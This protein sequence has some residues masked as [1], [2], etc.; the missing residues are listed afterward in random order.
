MPEH[1]HQVPYQEELYEATYQ[2]L[3]NEG[4]PVSAAQRAAKVVASDKVPLSRT[5]EQQKDIQDALTW[6]FAK[7]GTT[8]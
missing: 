4:V 2:V 8:V 7:K 1:L 5:P 6:M 3:I